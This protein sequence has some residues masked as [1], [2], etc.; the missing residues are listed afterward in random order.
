M[1][2]IELTLTGGRGFV[3]VDTNKVCAVCEA[4]GITE[5]YCIGSGSTCFAVEED[6]RD[7]MKKMNNQS[8][9]KWWSNKN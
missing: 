2:F 1:N 4:N 3:L 5:V 9:S 7:V 8:V 6:A